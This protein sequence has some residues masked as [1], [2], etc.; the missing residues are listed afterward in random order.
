MHTLLIST[1]I[2]PHV[3]GAELNVMERPGNIFPLCDLQFKEATP[4][5][6][7][8]YYVESVVRKNKLGAA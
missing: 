3:A 6:Y 5:V 1:L 8:L 2:K 7:E 4:C